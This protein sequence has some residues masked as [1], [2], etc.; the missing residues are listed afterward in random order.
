MIF[1]LI[2]ILKEKKKEKTS[3]QKG[4]NWQMLTKEQ[5]SFNDVVTDLEAKYYIRMIESNCS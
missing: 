1:F 3:C 4:D 2:N 5:V